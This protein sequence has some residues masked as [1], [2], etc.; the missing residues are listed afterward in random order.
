M[1]HPTPLDTALARRPRLSARTKNVC[2]TLETLVEAA[3]ASGRA[4][5]AN[6]RLTLIPDRPVTETAV[7]DE[8]G[9]NPDP[10]EHVFE[11]LEEIGVLVRPLHE[12]AHAHVPG[13]DLGLPGGQPAIQLLEG[14]RTGKFTPERRLLDDA[15]DTGLSREAVRTAARML[16]APGIVTLGH[17]YRVAP[18]GRRRV[19]LAERFLDTT[20]RAAAEGR[21]ATGPV[22]FSQLR[23]GSGLPGEL[24]RWLFHRLLDGR[25]ALRGDEP[26]TLVFGDPVQRR[27]LSLVL[28]D[29]QRNSSRAHPVK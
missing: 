15:L 9:L 4:T 12:P 20:I 1:T 8:F 5:G 16:V 28:K 21:L 26:N 18:D 24:E 17:S 10:A 27:T 13:K 3:A 6:G 7:R 2:R 25:L 29:R 14:I 19:L 23:H 11:I 22:S